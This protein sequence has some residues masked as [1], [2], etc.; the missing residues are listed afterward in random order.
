L[1]ATNAEAA[2]RAAQPDLVVPVP[3]HWRRRWQ[4]GY[5]QSAALAH[6][7]ASGLRLPCRPR[8]LRRIRSTPMQTQQTPAARRH[9][10]RGAFRAMPAVKDYSVLLVDD[11]LTTGSTVSEA[12]R[13]LLQAGARCVTVAVVARAAVKPSVSRDDQGVGAA[14]I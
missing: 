3:L 5:N 14:D 13:A 9:N 4:R 2:L 1:W 6:G 12:S 8:A 10:L 11:V 7:L